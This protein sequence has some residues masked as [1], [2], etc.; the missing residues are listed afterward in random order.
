MIIASQK[1]VEEIRDTLKAY[2]KILIAACGTCV[3]VCLAGGEKEA[4]EL[5]ELLSLS[6]DQEFKIVTPER[7]CDAEFLAEFDGDVG[8]ADAVLSMACGVGVQY[9]AERCTGKPVIPALNTSFMGANR[10]AGYWTEMCQGC[11]DCVLEKTGGVCPVARCSKSHFNGPCGGSAKG[12][13]EVDDSVDCGWQLIYDRLKSLN[14]LD[15]LYETIPP[16]NW[17]TS[18]DGGPRK[19]RRPDVAIEE[20]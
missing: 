4:K 15:R 3:T 14:Q 11:G 2:K 18:R 10:E 1:P 20:V 7:Q 6:G 16:R 9:M 12:K 8:Q 17:S 13:C 5:A 19:L